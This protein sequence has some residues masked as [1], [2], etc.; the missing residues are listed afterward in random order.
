LW[1]SGR[2]LG[3]PVTAEMVAELPGVGKSFGC[4][5]ELPQSKTLHDLQGARAIHSPSPIRNKSKIGRMGN[6]ARGA[7]DSAAGDDSD[8]FDF[9]ALANGA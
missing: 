4:D 5:R 7:A 1:S 8:E 2:R 6:T 3:A 9:I